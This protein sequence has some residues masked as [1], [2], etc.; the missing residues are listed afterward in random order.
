[1]DLSFIPPDLA[2]RSQYIPK[3]SFLDFII[4]LGGVLG[5]WLDLD[6]ISIF[7]LIP[8]LTIVISV[9]CFH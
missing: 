8:M 2:F 4:Y 3:L 6:L 5:P 7:D 9:F 1:M